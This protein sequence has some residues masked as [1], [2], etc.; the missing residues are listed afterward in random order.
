MKLNKKGQSMVEMAL[1]LP[2]VILLLMGMVELSRVFGSYLLV[3]HVSREGARLASIGRTD[4][5]I[6]ANLAGK[7]GILNVS[8]LQVILTPAD[9]ARTTGEDVRVCVKYKLQIYAP[10]ISSIVSNPFEMEANT[11]MRVE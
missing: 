4:A 8:E 6:Q 1:I 3:T 10:V 9:G 11:Y 7:A 5:E 2:L